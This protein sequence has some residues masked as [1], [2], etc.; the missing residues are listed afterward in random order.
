MKGMGELFQ[1]KIYSDILQSHEPGPSEGW[2][3]APGDGHILVEW[4]PKGRCHQGWNL[5]PGGHETGTGTSGLCLQIPS[6]C[7]GGVA[8]LSRRTD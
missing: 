2:L 5:M 3:L 6:C 4:Y 1:N 7:E 8:G